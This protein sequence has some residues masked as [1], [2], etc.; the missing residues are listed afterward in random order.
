MKVSRVQAAENR[1]RIIASAARL[2]REKGFDG[3]GV[4]DIMADAGLT[5]GGFYGH[6][7]SKD[8]LIAQACTHAMGESE[9]R[10][11]RH[12]ERESGQTLKDIVGRYVSARHRD[13]PGHG[14]TWAALGGELARQDGR[15]R[16]TATEGLRM[17]LDLLEP[18]VRGRTA[19]ERRRKALATYAEMVG[20]VMLA[21]AVN[22]AALSAEILEAAVADIAEGAPPKPARGVGGVPR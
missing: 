15:T 6:F 8:D 3:V 7:A 2:F 12:N 22:D 14:C 17:Q 20:A 19:A 21:R 11:T 5:H 18:S 1:E 13:D 10:W 4:A 16:A 9:A